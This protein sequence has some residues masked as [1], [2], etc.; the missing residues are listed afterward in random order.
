METTALAPEMT[1]PDD[2]TTKDLLVRHVML[3]QKAA[4]SAYLCF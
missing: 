1:A 3:I 4:L 2:P